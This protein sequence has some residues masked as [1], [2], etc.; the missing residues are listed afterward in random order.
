MTASAEWCLILVVRLWLM[1]VVVNAE[2]GEG[3]GRHGRSIHGE[4]KRGER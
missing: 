3:K 1:A 2:N 4:K